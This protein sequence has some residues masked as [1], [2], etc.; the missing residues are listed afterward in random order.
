MRIAI[1]NEDQTKIAIIHH[2][3]IAEPK[4]LID[5]KEIFPGKTQDM[6]IHRDNYLI[7]TEKEEE[8]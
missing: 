2:Y 3:Q 5:T 4:G 6:Y 8:K 7:I 1:K